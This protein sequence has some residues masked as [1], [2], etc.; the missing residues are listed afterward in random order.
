M[1]IR[2]AIP[3][4]VA[5]TN[6]WRKTMRAISR[7]EC[8]WDGPTSEALRTRELK[9]EKSCIEVQLEPLKETWKNYGCTIL[10]DGWS[11]VR[12]RNVYNVLVSC[13]KGTMFL[14]AIDASL[15]GLTVTGAFI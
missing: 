4:H 15:P 9:R 6:Q 2:C 11:D 14:K 8:E 3:F 1:F 10:C 12:R 7:I 5:K 13:C